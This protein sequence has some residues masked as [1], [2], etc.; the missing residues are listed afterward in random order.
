MGEGAE[1]IPVA[2]ISGSGVVDRASEEAVQ[3]AKTLL[4]PIEED[5]FR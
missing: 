4:R 2:L 5:L 1:G 3:N